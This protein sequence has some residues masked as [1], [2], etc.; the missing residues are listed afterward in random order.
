MRDPR[1]ELVAYLSD[2]YALERAGLRLLL[3]ASELGGEEVVRL[4]RDHSDRTGEHLRLVGERL[5]HHGRAL[6]IEQSHVDVGALRIDF[7][8]DTKQS[9]SGLA[10]SIYTLEGLQIALYHLLAALA[11]E[12]NDE[13]TQ[14]LAESILEQE[15]EAAELIANA[16]VDELAV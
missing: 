2:T 5:E 9:A 4:Y 3:R 14:R 10:I 7:Q 1:E 15:E 12:C 13:L 11:R 16:M 8:L 6:P